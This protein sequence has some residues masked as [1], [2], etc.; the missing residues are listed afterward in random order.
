MPGRG[1]SPKDPDKRARRNADPVASRTLPLVRSNAPTLPKDVLPAGIDWHPAVKR[2]WDAWRR[3]P[4]AAD[5]TEVE[6]QEM[7][8]TA[9][10]YHDFYSG[11]R[12]LAGELRLRMAKVGATS[13]DRAR[14]RIVLADASAKE[15]KEPANPSAAR[16]RYAN[17]RR[18][19]PMDPED[20]QATG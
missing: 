6:W 3:S 15:E 19:A 5:F 7:L 20:G 4:L 11:D 14:L 13:E 18:L 1:P 8:A 16:Q 2:W 12:K 9:V 17:V 10:L